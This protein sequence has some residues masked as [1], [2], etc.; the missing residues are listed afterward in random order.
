MLKKLLSPLDIRNLFIDNNFYILDENYARSAQLDIYQLKRVKSRFNPNTILNLR[1]YHPEKKWY[2]IE[3]DFCKKQKIELVN[4]KLSSKTNP[5]KK[6]ILDILD[7][8]KNSKKPLLVHCNGGSERTGLVSTIYEH[9]I[10]QKPISKAINQSSYKYGNI[11]PYQRRFFK[12]YIK[13]TGGK[14]FVK[15]ILSNCE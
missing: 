3:Q 14:D 7:I 12:R 13:A 8:L 10:K 15:W 4:I 5:T 11:L 2:E 9:V 6:Q 1:G